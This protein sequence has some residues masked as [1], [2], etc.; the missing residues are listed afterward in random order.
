MKVGYVRVSSEDQN[1]ARQEV[2]MK[3]LGV[4]KVYIDKA[5]GKNKERKK[6]K[7]MFDF[8][9]E[10]DEVIVESISRFARNTKDLLEL[11]EQLKEKGVQFISKK[12]AIDTSTP[13][14]EFMLTVFGAMAQLERAYILDRQKEGIAIAKKEGKYKG[15]KPIEVDDILFDTLYKQWKRKEITATKFM[16]MVSLK[17]NT[18]YRKVKAYEETRGIVNNAE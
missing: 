7:E 3:E 6:L 15:R 10:G 11:V 8:V 9:R 13:T 1:T 16:D 14:G 2:L 12:E 4:E 18:F 5:S 17:P